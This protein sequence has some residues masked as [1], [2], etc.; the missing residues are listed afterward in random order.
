MKTSLYKGLDE[1]GKSDLKGSFNASIL[2]RKQLTLLLNDENLR[3]NEEMLKDESFSSPNWNL[4]QV[5]RIAQIK[6][7]NNLINLL[8]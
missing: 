2:L 8:K 4:D 7:N 1:E 5:A 3:L 6:A